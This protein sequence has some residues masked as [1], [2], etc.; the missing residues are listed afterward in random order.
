MVTQRQSHTHNH[1][2]NEHASKEQQTRSLRPA[3][4]TKLFLTPPSAAS[5]GRDSDESRSNDTRVTFLTRR[6]LTCTDVP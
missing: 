1:A 4:L 6:L 3:A 5:V 2:H